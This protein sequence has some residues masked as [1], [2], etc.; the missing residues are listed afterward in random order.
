M[1]DASGLTLDPVDFL[2]LAIASASLIL[3]SFLAIWSLGRQKRFHS[4]E[5]VSGAHARLHRVARA[6]E[7]MKRQGRFDVSEVLD[8][9]KE[10]DEAFAMVDPYLKLSRRREFAAAAEKLAPGQNL[11]DALNN[12]DLERWLGLGRDAIRRYLRLA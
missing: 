8:I 9:V 4:F 12:G 3:S 2:T 6:A 1:P 7:L 10:A 5:I 11:Q